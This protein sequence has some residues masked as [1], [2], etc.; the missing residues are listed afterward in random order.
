MTAF[1]A[2]MT[3]AAGSILLSAV[4]AAAAS[5]VSQAQG[6]FLS[7]S[8]LATNLDNIAGL[9]PASAVNDGSTTNVAS[10]HPLDATV[11]NA[12]NADL[13]SGLNLFGANGV[14]TLGAVDQFASASSNGSSKAASGAVDNNGAIAVGGVNGVPSSDATIDLTKVLG[15]SAGPGLSVLSA[16]TVAVGAVS[17]TADETSAG[18]QTGTYKIASLKLNLT[19]PL[20]T[21]VTSSL[22][23]VNL[24][25]Q[26]LRD[27][28]LLGVAQLS[29]VPDLARLLAD[30]G[31]VSTADGSITVNISTGVVSIDV[32][33]V[34][35]AAGLDLNNLP[36]NTEIV[37][38]IVTAV[39][40]QLPQLITG[41]VNS[42]ITQI[43]TAIGGIT[44]SALGTG[45]NIPIGQLALSGLTTTVTAPLTAA[46]PTLG[47]SVAGPLGT[48]LSGLLSLTGNVQS[49]TAG[50]FNQTALRLTLIPGAQPLARVG[51]ASA[52]V[53]NNSAPAT[54]TTAS[55]APNRG[56]VTGGTTVVITGANFV[57][58]GTAVTIG[59]TTVPAT[60]V[61]V[62]P[63]G[64]TATFS[65]P[66]HAVGAVAVTVTTGGGTSTPALTYTY[67][68]LAASSL[69]PTHGPAVGGTSVTV[70]GSGFVPGAT[71]VTIGSATIPST[72]VAVNP[73]G[74]SATFTTVAHA[75]GPVSVTVTT[76]GGTTSPPLTY[77][78]DPGAPTG[79]SLTPN[80]GPAIGGTEV[81]VTGTGFVQGATSV[82]IGGIIVPAGQVTVGNGGT[83]ATF[84]TPAHPVGQV[85]VTVTTGAG[86]TTPPL[87][88]T[89]D[90]PTAQAISPNTGPTTGGTPVTITGSGFVAGSTSV[91]IGGIVVPASAV[92]V[93]N[94]TTLQFV[95]PAHPAGSVAV[96][97]TTPDGTSTPP[98]GFFYGTASCV[99]TG[100]NAATVTVNASVGVNT[101]LVA[102][103]FSVI[104]N[105]SP[106]G[107][108][109]PVIPSIGGILQA[110]SSVPVAAG[111]T[112]V[113]YILTA[114]NGSFTVVG[115]PITCTDL[116][117]PQREAGIYHPLQSARL[118]DTRKS[119][120]L[121]P[122]ATYTLQV[123]GRGGVPATKV[124]SL[125][126]N[127]TVT[128]PAKAGFLTVYPDGS[129]PNT[130]SVNFAPAQTV[131]NLMT[132]PV[133]TDGKIRIYNGSAGK[134][135]V[136]VD[137]SGYFSSG[138]TVA[139]GSYKRLDPV[140]ILD[141]N[142]S[143]GVQTSTPVPANGV[144]TLKVTGVGGVQATNVSAVAL[145]VTVDQTNKI[146]FIT[147]FKSGSAP[148]IS[149][150]NFLPKQ[151]SANLV[152]APVAPDGTIKIKNAS[153]GTVRLI[154]DVSGYFLGGVAIL[155][156]EFVAVTPSRILDT[157]RTSEPVQ[158]LATISPTMVARN[159]I[160]ATGASAVILNVTADHTKGIG[161][162]TVFPRDPRPAASNLNFVANEA[163]PNSV[164]APLGSD[165]K[166]R[167]FNGSRGT[168]D[169]IADVSGYFISN[170]LR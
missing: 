147:V 56:P 121:N 11:L 101:A 43:G 20:I 154:A 139:P 14:I 15:S 92:I 72:K 110:Q 25:D 114:L 109:T 156:G 106:V 133:G 131:A 148:Q 93:A 166:V 41:S 89:Y 2:A 87:T 3:M 5:T 12:V 71:T 49:T 66:A 122:G 168:V 55:L 77:T 1:T 129:R 57:P 153:S 117:G 135:H 53:G 116:T 118:L 81:T 82:T 69:S 155:D 60:N 85:Q 52:S 159:E 16:G 31:P 144:L 58:G 127:V 28:N 90:A 79:S 145:N 112:T 33:K 165:G 51:L 132:A 50:K 150:L 22:T 107:T 18:A 76:A 151:T 146:G 23:T 78:F 98:L 130:S 19:S 143:I 160:P 54:P 21:Q 142:R 46:L 59:G 94:S 35:T 119:V 26:L 40:D 128:E 84:T 27:V 102:S 36:A 161:Y 124:A 37:P 126:A 96:T 163:R 141:T 29:N 164:I 65:T 38:I 108:P 39:T 105:G 149:S 42:L 95:T 67:D 34:L 80:H 104:V 103:S 162:I 152:I 9:A 123:L 125:V 83:T 113:S 10:N 86:T 97:V 158:A 62:N 88:Y 48:T 13:G 17:A 115:D 136:L 100:G 140:R 170:P 68:P 7:G 63:A 30:V 45:L 4:P 64:T 6:R 120:A 138:D 169:L 74:T 61:T 137:V 75:V 47:T 24:T 111:T 44:A 73:T 157:R 167:M 99:L 32:A 70:T 134:T 91:T 8:V